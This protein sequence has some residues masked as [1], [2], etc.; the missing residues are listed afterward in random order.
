MKYL[1]IIIF[2]IFS[3]LKI[4]SNNENIN[5]DISCET[6]NNIYK[7]FLQEETYN[8]L[9]EGLKDI[10][11][12][13]IKFITNLNVIKGDTADNYKSIEKLYDLLQNIEHDCY[14]FFLDIVFQPLKFSEQFT[15][16]LLH[17]GGIIQYSIGIEEDCMGSDDAYLFFSGEHN[18]TF[19]RDKN[20]T[21]DK[22]EALFRESNYMYEEYC[23]FSKCRHFYKPLVDYLIEYHSSTINKIFN[24]EKVKLVGI[25][26]TDIYDNETVQKTKE[27]LEKEENE[28]SYYNIIGYILILVGFFYAFCIIY[29]WLIRANNK[30]IDTS[31]K[32]LSDMENLNGGFQQMNLEEENENLLLQK[33]K[34]C[35]DLPSYKFIASF[36]FISNLS[37]I[38]VKSERLNNQTSL[39]E[40]L[41]LLKLFILFFLMLGENCYIVLKFIDNKMS[42]ISLNKKF[43]FFIIKLG[44]NSYESY[45]VLCGVIFGFKFMNYYYKYEKININK[46]LRFASKPIQ[47]MLMFIIIHFFFNYPIFIYMKK[48]FSNIKN[49][50]FAEVI[51]QYP[52]QKSPGA[53]FSSIFKYNSIKF[54]IGMYNGCS[55]PILFVFN[56]IICFYIVLIIALINTHFKNWISNII[57]ICFFILNFIILFLSYFETRE[58]EDLI[59]EFTISRLFGLSGSIALPHLFFPLYYFGF[60]IGVIY[61]YHLN[62][63]S[64]KLI[65]EKEKED[66]KDMPF[67][68][69]YS[70]ASY[71]TGIRQ[72]YKNI[73]ML[74]FIVLLL[75]TSFSYTI[76]V[77]SIDIEKIV[78]TF[79]E[80]PISKFLYAYDGIFLGLFFS[81]FILIYL[82]SNSNIFISN[83]LSSEFFLFI[84]KISFVFFITFISIL[85]FFHA[86]GLMEIYLI[87][88]S[89]FTNTMIL[90]IISCII[91]ILLTCL[92][93]FPIKWVYLYALNGFYNEDYKYIS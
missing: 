3:N 61:Y 44:M 52:C 43:S 21:E 55:R 15:K 17:D 69:C 92:F 53:V 32:A 66:N 18:I 68:Y 22:R 85:D 25:N 10:R 76:L 58:R 34:T 31:Y 16:A 63:L 8:P 64:N 36:D 24:W 77:N 60:N 83:A 87:V 65:A 59:N 20:S 27:E 67:I 7:N 47:Y 75:G 38:N 62:G 13:L 12:E 56:E 90:F 28:N 74:I 57:Y 41:S 79:E 42:I 48:F 9:T 84:H 86:I 71:I 51:C 70:I 30:T 45:K 33:E 39:L 40:L 91:S 46:A 54:N 93:L 82:C 81:F 4:I 50:Y 6:S 2:L 88:F 5:N 19:L 89:I 73:F 1:I 78:F 11:E 14:N 80:K 35:T 29:S 49:N 23:L 72:K 37:L 26:F